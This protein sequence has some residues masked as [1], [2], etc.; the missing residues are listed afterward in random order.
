MYTCKYAIASCLRGTAT[1]L[2]ITFL[3]KIVP[4]VM[5]QVYII[6]LCMLIYSA[7]YY[8]RVAREGV[9]AQQQRATKS[10]EPCP[11]L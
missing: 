4:A 11:T 6:H 1:P 10:S 3:L 5:T 8:P 2:F 7:I 9:T